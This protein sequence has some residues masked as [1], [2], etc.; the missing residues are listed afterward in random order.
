MGNSKV[1]VDFSTTKYTDARLYSKANDII[2][3]MDGN[4]HFAD[5]QHLL[6]HLR[7]ATTTYIAALA[8]TRGRSKKNTALK[9]QARTIL[10]AMLK[11]IAT[12][13]QVIS[14]GDSLIILNSGY[15]VKKKWSKVGPL[16]KPTNF[17]IKQG[18]NKGSIYL[19]CNPI[20]GA[21]LY[22]FEYTEGIPTPNSIWI[23]VSSTKR[24]IT[25]DELISGKQ[26]TFRIAG[27]GSHPSRIWSD[28]ISSYVV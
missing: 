10:I 6:I 25:I 27:G 13:V 11:Q 21:R 12:H 1:I 8:K 22:E 7:E 19:V 3:R 28:E 24:K 5:I 23:K 2:H 4:P 9:N 20:A 18:G 15:D 17:K 16:S 26:Y 14:D